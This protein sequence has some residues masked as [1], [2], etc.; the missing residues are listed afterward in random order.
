MSEGAE[1]KMHNKINRT[2]DEILVMYREAF[3]PMTLY[4]HL[5]MVVTLFNLLFLLNKWNVSG[6]LLF[7]QYDKL[8]EIRTE[9]TI[10]H[11]LLECWEFNNKLENAEV[12]VIWS[13]MSIINFLKCHKGFYFP[14]L[15]SIKGLFHFHCQSWALIIALKSSQL[16]GGNSHLSHFYSNQWDI[17]MGFGVR[18]I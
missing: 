15:H 8:K 5:L 1:G 18:E 14:F 9:G 16:K 17:L 6:K 13:S 3:Y 4:F 11:Y 2:L 10:L 7:S 12:D